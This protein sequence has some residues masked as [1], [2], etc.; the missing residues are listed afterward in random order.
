MQTDW[1]IGLVIMLLSMLAVVTDLNRDIELMGY[2]LGVRFSSTKSANQDVVIIKID[3]ASLQAKGGWPWP[4]DILAEATRKLSS[5]RPAVIGYVLPLDRE[6]S[7]HGLEYINEL[8]SLV[9]KESGSTNAQMKRLLNKA[10]V[11][12]QF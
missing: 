10:K 3:E 1:I 4:R 7:V 11:K 9:Q 5:A 2:D 12:G 8:Q 6:Q